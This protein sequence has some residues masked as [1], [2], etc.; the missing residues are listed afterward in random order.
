MCWSSWFPVTSGRRTGHRGPRLRRLPLPALPRR[1]RHTVPPLLRQVERDVRASQELRQA[2]G[3]LEPHCRKQLAHGIF[4]FPSEI[5][6]VGL[7]QRFSSPVLWH[8][9]RPNGLLDGYLFT[10]GSS[11][12]S[13]VLRR[14]GWA[15]V[16]GEHQVS[17]LR[18]RADRRAARADIARRR[19][20]RCSH[21]RAYHDGSARAAHRLRWD[22]RHHQRAKAWASGEKKGRTSGAGCTAPTTRSR[23]SRSRAM[24]T[25]GEVHRQGAPLTC[26]DG[27]TISPRKGLTHTQATRCEAGTTRRQQR[28]HKWA[29]GCQG[30]GQSAG[31]SRRWRCQRHVRRPIGFP[32]TTPSR[33]SQD[34]QLDPRSFR[35]H[36]LHIGRV[37]NQGGR[38]MD[39]PI[40]ICAKCGAMYWEKGRRAV[41]ELPATSLRLRFSAPQIEVWAVPEQTLPRL[42]SRGRSATYLGRGDDFRGAAGVVRGGFG[43]NGAWTNNREEAAYKPPCCSAG[44]ETTPWPTTQASVR[45]SVGAR[46]SLIWVE[47]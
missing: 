37:L 45:C 38:T 25:E 19:G 41:L 5:L 17:R 3:S 43:S 4:P 22:H 8:N 21:G 12:G 1:A 24:R 6:P 26:S 35:R 42:E 14:A 23:R 32:P 7:R 15:V 29:C 40:V 2:A 33:L 11:S 30:P 34:S 44:T 10:D 13:G 27:K 18:G 46:C 39:R 36:S 47:S 28:G 9:R 16:A 20:V 31:G